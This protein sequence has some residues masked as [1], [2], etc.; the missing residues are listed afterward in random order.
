MQILDTKG[1]CGTTRLRSPCRFGCRRHRAT[2]VSQVSEQ[3]ALGFGALF[4]LQRAEADVWT[5]PNP[6]V[7]RPTVF[8]GQVAAQAVLAASGTVEPDQRVHSLHAYFL[9]GGLPGRPMTVAVERTRDGRSFATR[10]V[11]AI[12]DD[13]VVCSAMLSFHRQEPSFDLLP[14]MPEV[15]PPDS[16][17]QMNSDQSSEAAVELRAIPPG[18]GDSPLGELRVWVRAAEPLAGAPS[19]DAAALVFM[20][21]LKTG[22]SIGVGLGGMSGISMVSSLDHAFWLHRPAPADRW[23]L[24][25]VRTQAFAHARGLVLGMLHSEDGDAVATFAQELVLR[26]RQL[27][28]EQPE[29][30]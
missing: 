26:P 14:G 8:G 18:L 3:N 15:P 27:A 6:P 20:S 1:R 21:D 23:L 16:C 25:S 17:A 11:E 5:V 4:D 7:S 24:M 28:E 10:R 30:R 29:A 13:V 2:T 22:N 19:L 9:R 12:Q